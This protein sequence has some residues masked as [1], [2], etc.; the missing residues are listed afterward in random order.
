[1]KY[2]CCVCK[3]IVSEKDV[4]EE[5]S[6]LVPAYY[7]SEKCVHKITAHKTA[8]KKRKKMPKSVSNAIDIFWMVIAIGFFNSVIIS[9][10]A[11]EV[12][13][14]L[15][16]LGII[17]FLTYML[18]EGNNWARIILLILLIIGIPMSF[19]GLIELWYISPITA[20]ISIG[21]SIAQVY[22]LFLL[23][24]KSSSQWFEA[25]MD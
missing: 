18:K 6:G 4:I 14:I 7:C 8:A 15:F 16:S 1:M 11:F 25:M 13:I 5:R 3:K 21:L 19:F 2:V 10:S 20:I 12:F 24:Q 17:A 23:F 9:T 22:A